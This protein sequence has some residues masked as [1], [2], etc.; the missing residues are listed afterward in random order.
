MKT[1]EINAFFALTQPIYTLILR[2]IVKEPT[3]TSLPDEPQ[4]VLLTYLDSEL[5]HL[6]IC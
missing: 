4:H 6:N 3:V 1:P 2:W 5:S